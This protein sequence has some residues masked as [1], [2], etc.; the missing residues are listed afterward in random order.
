M[1][2]KETLKDVFGFDSFRGGQEKII[3][4]VLLGQSALAVFPTGS[5]KSLCYQLPAVMLPGLTIVISPLIALMKDQV[6]FL[7]SRSIKVAR[8][9]SSLNAEETRDVF[10]EIRAGMLKLLYVAPERISNERFFAAIENVD[11]SLMVIDEAHCISEWGHN[12]RPEYL[13]L[14]IAAKKLSVGSVLALTATATPSVVKDIRR[15]FSIADESYVNTGFHRPNL[16]LAFSP[17]PARERMGVLIK[18]LS[19]SPAGPTIVYVTLQKEAEDV[20]ERLVESGFE[21]KAYHAGMKSDVRSVI[22]DWFMESNDGIVVA[23]IAF[24]MGID[25]SNIRRVYHYNLPKTLENY[26]QEIGRAGRDGQPSHCEILGSGEDLIVLENFIYGDTPTGESIRALVAFILSQEEEFDVSTY[27]LSQQTDIRPLVLSTLLTYLELEGVIKFTSPFYSEY[28][29]KYLESKRSILDSI[30]GEPGEFLRN[31]LAQASDKKTWSYLKIDSAVEALRCDRNRI[32][33]AFNYLEEKGQLEV[34]VTGLRQGMRLLNRTNVDELTER[35]VEKVARNEKGNMERTRQVVE[36]MNVES[37][38]TQ[39]VL[40]YFGEELDEP[41]GHC[42]FCSTNQTIPLE[43]IEREMT[44]EERVKMDTFLDERPIG[45]KS[46]RENARF[47][48]GIVSPSLT[49]SKATK[50]KLFGTLAKV[51]FNTILQSLE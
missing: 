42:S 29:F 15:E 8:L 46:A 4:Q 31:V 14:S 16:F 9:D 18:K 6:D 23:T 28:K 50:D 22:Q 21:A 27:H 1:E 49:R 7:L 19:S 40:R 36:M 17:T 47:L 41:C 43:G 13:K 12:F 5:G 35:L 45:F 10:N 24:G 48:C 33:K 37:C 25:K 32:V 20:A 34:T 2:Y 38:K 3:S 30:S 39:Y 44:D 11:I 26:S 51:P